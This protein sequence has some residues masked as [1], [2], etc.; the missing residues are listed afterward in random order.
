MTVLTID[1]FKDI[2]RPVVTGAG[3]NN[4]KKMNHIFR[5]VVCQRQDGNASNDDEEM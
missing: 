3:K 2:E 5:H 4:Q 1:V